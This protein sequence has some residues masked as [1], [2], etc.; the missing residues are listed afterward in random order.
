MKTSVALNV[1]AFNESELVAP[2]IEG[3]VL[4][5]LHEYFTEI[6]FVDDGSQD[7]TLT[8]LE[9]LKSASLNFHIVRHQA[10]RGLG[11]AIRSGVI[12][13]SATEVCWVPIDLS[14]EIGDV[15][16]EASREDRSDVVL[17]KR[18]LRNETGRGVV[19]FFAHYTFRLIFGCDVRHQSGI[20]I[21]RRS[22][23]LENMPITQRAIANLEFIIRL[24]K[25]NTSVEHVNIVCH[26]RLAGTSKTFSGRSV[27]R[28]LRELIGLVLVDPRLVRRRTPKMLRSRT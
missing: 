5:G 4:H 2:F 20:F 8:Q 23:F 15:V 24:N 16:R 28:S 13:A 26:P 14:F 9:S 3:L 21:M 1:P 12:A 19:S 10:N 18:V 7:T 17:F 22:L 27:L 6:I 11:A 25:A